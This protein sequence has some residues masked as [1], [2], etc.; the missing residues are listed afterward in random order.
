VSR[1]EGHARL[2]AQI[3]AEAALHPALAAIVRRQQAAMRSA[4]ADLLPDHD[5]RDGIAEAFVALAGGYVGQLA[6][7]DDV[8]PAPF[9]GALMAIVRA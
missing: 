8:D 3:Q 9:A 2:V 1:D 4:V 7:R 6:V 5:D